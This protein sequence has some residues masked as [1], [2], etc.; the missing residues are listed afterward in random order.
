MEESF[1]GEIKIFGGT[2]APSGWAF[3]DG[4]RLSVEENGLLFTL[5]GNTY[6][7]DGVN[8]FALPDLR[9]RVPLGYSQQFRLGAAG[10]EE[11]HV[12]TLSEMPKHNHRVRAS[13]LTAQSS[14]PEGNLWANNSGLS[15][16]AAKP[17]ALMGEN[18]LDVTG[19]GEPHENMSPFL[20]LNFAVSVGGMLSRMGALGEIIMYCGNDLP[21]GAWLFGDW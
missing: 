21:S 13:S 18:N 11:R 17:N 15:P 9:G 10:G 6:G 4:A 16:F 12:L 8:D 1:V 14:S 7:G 2:F 19:A 20:A 3:C 5:I